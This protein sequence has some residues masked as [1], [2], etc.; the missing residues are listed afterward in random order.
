MPKQTNNPLLG[1]L[2]NF[3][4]QRMTFIPNQLAIAP[5]NPTSPSHGTPRRSLLAGELYEVVTI[6][7][8]VSEASIS[9]AVS[10][11]RV[12][13]QPASKMQTAVHASNDV[14]TNEVFATCQYSKWLKRGLLSAVVL[15]GLITSFAGRAN[16]QQEVDATSSRSARQEALRQI[17]FHEITKDAQQKLNPILNRPT[18]YRRLP[19][20]NI[21]C[22]PDLHIFF[23][24][25]PE[26]MVSIWQMM[27]V[28]ECDATRTGDYSVHASDGEGTISDL[29]LVYGTP[30]LHI[31][32]GTGS[33]DGPMFHKKLTGRC[34]LVLRT[35]YGVDRFGAPIVR[36]QL[37]TFI[38]I[39]NLAADLVARTF[40]Q[41]IGKTADHNFLETS[42]FLSRISEA[43]EENAYGVQHMGARLEN[44][45]AQVRSDFVRIVGVVGKRH[46]ARLAKEAALRSSTERRIDAI[47]VSQSQSTSASRPSSGE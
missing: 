16:A 8:E 35:E 3:E 6:P 41:L 23:V 2:D 22:D 11:S 45:D 21:E 7:Y 30:N 46:E 39:D 26:V 33:Y 31:Y 40:H 37:D 17:P 14:S 32:Y 18:V 5:S 9:L 43:A 36:N 10:S 29:E 27:G 13:S 20:E 38:K 12:E 1:P 44:V 4:G 24:R 15:I 28:T 25:Y 47:P 42:R 19:V 34:V